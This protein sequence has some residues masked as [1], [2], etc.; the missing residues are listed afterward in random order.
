MNY[1]A[2]TCREL[3]HY[4][5]LNSTDP[6]VRKLVQYF[7]GAGLITELEQAG[8]DPATQTFTEDNDIMDP[9][10]YIES[11][12]RR[13]RYA[14]DDLSDLQFKYEQAVE[15]R[16]EL[17]TRSIMDFVEEVWQEK[18]TAGY[19]VTEALK[20]AEHQRQE[21][22]RLREQIDMWGRMNQPERKLS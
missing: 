14:E 8:M 16:D 20:E 2:M 3:I 1:D 11:L 10:E 13:L 21:N 17:K 9:G 15:E 7:S 19:K 12:R 5:D 6:V 18:R 4:L 22:A